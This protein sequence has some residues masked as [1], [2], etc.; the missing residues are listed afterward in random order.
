M[1]GLTAGAAP[2][3]RDAVANRLATMRNAV[4]QLD[5]AGPLDRARLD[6]DPASGLVVER[7]LSLL[8][9]CVGRL[10]GYVHV[11]EPVRLAELTEYE[12]PANLAVQ[13]GDVVLIRLGRVLRWAAEGGSDCERAPDGGNCYHGLHPEVLTCLRERDVALM[14]SEMIW[15]T[16]S[17]LSNSD[18]PTR[19]T[20]APS[21][22]WGFL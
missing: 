19:Y 3:D 7:T 4:D 14:V 1:G 9:V 12:A 5:A 6:R 16:I 10:G 11:D 21:C 20:S 2:A 22:S 18:W 8:D 13:P 17:S 15:D